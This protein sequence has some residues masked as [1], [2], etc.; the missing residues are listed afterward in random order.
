MTKNKRGRPQTEAIQEY[1][2]EWLSKLWSQPPSTGVER[3]MWRRQ[4]D[5]VNCGVDLLVDI[6]EPWWTDKDWQRAV[7][8][9]LELHLYARILDD[10][11]DEGLLVHRQQALM[12]QEIVWKVA[13]NIGSSWPN[14][15]DESAALIKTTVIG[16]AQDN[17]TESG[18]EFWAKKNYHLLI[19]P[20][21]LSGNDALF[22]EFQ[23]A[24]SD[25]LF[26][27]QAQEECDESA[28][29]AAREAILDW[30]DRWLAEGGWKGLEK[31]GWVD[32]SRYLKS[33]V[34]Q[35]LESE[36]C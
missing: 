26:L 33:I 12:A 16:A 36:Q 24:L 21:L 27:L 9:V 1:G 31:A 28:G 32:F 22:R 14:L 8:L 15:L 29:E 4:S 23:D 6:T 35:M 20:L 2:N 30:I 18:D 13:T 7:S 11:V 25:G 3:L 17:P 5:T 34:Y 19:A 10:A